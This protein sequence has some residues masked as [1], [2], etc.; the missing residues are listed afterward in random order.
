MDHPDFPNHWMTGEF[1]EIIVPERLVFTSKAFENE[2]GVALLENINT[3][4]F[5]EFEGKT[6]LTV[7]AAVIKAAPEMAFAL[8]GMDQGWN[9]SLDKLSEYLP[10]IK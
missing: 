10:G 7:H 3:I 9:E 4:S 5:T 1:L 8:A 2:D 6:K